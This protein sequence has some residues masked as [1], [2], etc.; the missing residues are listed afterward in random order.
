MEILIRKIITA[1][2]L[3]RVRQITLSTGFFRDDE[4][5]VAVEL[6]T[7]AFMK[8]QEQSGYFF[9]FSMMGDHTTGYVCYGPTPCTM[10]TYD[11]YWIV[12]DNNYR[13]NGT[14]KMLMQQTEKELIARKARKL[15]IETSSTEKYLPTRNFYENCG[16]IE[17]ARLK[18]FYSNGDDKVIYSKVL[19]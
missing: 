2:D 12:V 11:L 18:D 10:G 15:Y 3:D 7:E 14:G 16:Y 17:E 19:I 8:G 13:G 6:V 5:E 1:N 9:L 4:V